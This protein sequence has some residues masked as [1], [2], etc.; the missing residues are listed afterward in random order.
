LSIGSTVI[1]VA[2]VDRAMRFWADALDYVPRDEPEESWVVLVPRDGVGA[3]LSLMRSDTQSQHHP[4]VHLDLYAPDPAT[5]ID[6]LL[7][8]G[9]R[10]VEEWDGYDEDSDFTVIEDPDGN[11]FCVVDTSNR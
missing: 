11:R 3:Q 5:E 8:L 2:D 6:R 10:R 9:A 7:G 4:R 1:G